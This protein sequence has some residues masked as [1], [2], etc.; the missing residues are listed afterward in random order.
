MRH[1]KGEREGGGEISPVLTETARF[2]FF[3]RDA[4]VLRVRPIGS[5]LRLVPRSR[6]NVFLMRFSALTFLGFLTKASLALMPAEVAAPQSGFPRVRERERVSDLIC[7]SNTKPGAV[8]ERR[9]EQRGRGLASEY[10]WHHAASSSIFF[11]K[12]RSHDDRGHVAPTENR[13]LA[14]RSAS[15]PISPS[16]FACSARRLPA[17]NKLIKKMLNESG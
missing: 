16:V 11:N 4:H 1:S 14:P 8:K 5:S 15:D 7:A 9:G 2:R 10:D 3:P 17:Q 12:T 6:R 13:L